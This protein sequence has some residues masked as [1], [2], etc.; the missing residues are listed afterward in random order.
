MRSI[1]QEESSVIKAIE[2]AWN[3]AGQPE[4]FS[5][6][7]FNTEKKSFF[8]FVKKMAIISLV[9]DPSKIL[10]E[11]ER[12]KVSTTRKFSKN[13][14]SQRGTA[15]RSWQQEKEKE[16]VFRE[17]PRDR[18]VDDRYSRAR[19][20]ADKL[21]YGRWTNELIRDVNTWVVELV[22]AMGIK[23]N[24]TLSVSQHLLRVVFDK[25]IISDVGDER[26]L[27]S[28][29]A[30]LLMQFLKRKYK[31]KFRGHKLAIVSVK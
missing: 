7:I 8:G 26:L 4:E 11:E 20:G 9:F 27:F 29:L 18:T 21:L 1:L 24:F 23:A 10:G 19:E 30:Y 16:K 12:R 31:K 28:S 22:D 13:F 3:K 6:K 5:I 14:N 15:G 17:A 2:K 25:P